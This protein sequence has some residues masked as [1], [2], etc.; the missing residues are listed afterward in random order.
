MKQVLAVRKRRLGTIS[1]VACAVV[2][3]AG[4]GGAQATATGRRSAAPA[5]LVV[6]VSTSSGQVGDTFTASGDACDAGIVTYRVDG[7][8]QRISNL[9]GDTP[10]PTVSGT[11][12]FTG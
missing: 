1:F 2:A 3:V 11:S 9:N 10:A 8:N 4:I 7:G 5:L 6:S 12:S